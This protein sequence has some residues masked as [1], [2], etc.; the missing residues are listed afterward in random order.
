MSGEPTIKGGA[1][2]IDVI[3]AARIKSLGPAEKIDMIIRSV[4]EGNVVFLQRG[5]TGEEK[6][7]LI[8]QTMSVVEPNEFEGIEIETFDP[9]GSEKEKSGG[10]F[11]RFLGDSNEDE[12]EKQLVVIAPAEKLKTLKKEKDMMRALVQNR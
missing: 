9:E 7:R 6:N 1:V 4:Q 10:L 11:N 8:E 3:S 2:S 5:L 12:L